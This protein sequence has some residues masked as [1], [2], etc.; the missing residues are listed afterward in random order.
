MSR[1][2][3]RLAET[4]HRQLET[5]AKREQTPLNQYIVYAL[6]RQAT[7]AYTVHELPEEA[8]TRQRA[9]FTTLLQTLGHASFDQIEK[10]MAQRE[11][12]TPE[13]GLSPK[14]RQPVAKASGQSTPHRSRTQGESADTRLTL[15]FSRTFSLLRLFAIWN[16][17]LTRQHQA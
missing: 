6:A 9:V 2:T 13:K 14:S 12:I 15:R 7:E 11:E 10:V 4:L 3:L 8:V 5:L 16:W 17:V 1:L